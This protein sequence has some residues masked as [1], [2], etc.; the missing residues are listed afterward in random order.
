MEALQVKLEYLHLH[1]PVSIV[2]REF[3][4]FAYRRSPSEDHFPTPPP[5]SEA[6]EIEEARITEAESRSEL[7]KE[8][9]PPCHPVHLDVPTL[10]QLPEEYAGIISHWQSIGCATFIPLKAQLND[11]ERFR[12][13]QER[14]RP[15]MSRNL[16]VYK[17]KI[18]DRRQK[19]GLEEDLSLHMALQPDPKQQGPLENWIE[20]QHNHLGRHESME[21]E[22]QEIVE[23]IDGRRRQVKEMAGLQTKLAQEHR[24]GLELREN[25]LSTLNRRLASHA[26][27]LRWIEA[28]RLSMLEGHTASAHDSGEPGDGIQH[29]QL[30]LSNPPTSTDRKRERRP[31]PAT[32]S[33][34]TG[35]TKNTPQRR[36]LRSQQAGASKR[37]CPRDTA[38]I[39]NELYAIRSTGPPLSHSD[40]TKSRPAGMKSTA[41]R[42]FRP[43]KIG[44]ATTKVIKTKPSSRSIDKGLSKSKRSR[45]KKTD[46]TQKIMHQ[47]PTTRTGRIPKQP[48]R[49][50]SG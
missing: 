33:V 10:Q 25:W 28:Q 45:K 5:L 1:L 38:M 7:I 37:K 4:N 31:H 18:F 27:L 47:H 19:H 23:E 41:L 29:G 30:A 14:I 8:G 21:A 26:E 44:K 35:I 49:F 20:F 2:L 32:G 22:V 42:P 48:N 16:P 6:E 34:P 11:W 12:N 9:C 24:L 40:T 36:S 50:R 13:W 46:Q 17:Q 43:Q 15:W 39:L 3:S